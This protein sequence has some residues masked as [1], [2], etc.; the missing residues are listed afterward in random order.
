MNSP[1]S[2]SPLMSLAASACAVRGLRIAVVGDRDAVP[3]PL[4]PRLITYLD[5]TA[6]GRAHAGLEAFIADEVLPLYANT[7]SVTTS[8]GIQSEQYMAEAR[9]VIRESVNASDKDDAVLFCG[10]GASAASSLLAHLLLGPPDGGGGSTGSHACL[11]PACHRTFSSTSELLLHARTHPDGD[12][13]AHKSAAAA[14]ASVSASTPSNASA[15]SLPAASASPAPPTV[16]IGPYVHH[17]SL[18]PWRERGAHIVHVP[19]AP[20]ALGG[21]VNL[22]ALEAALRTARPGEGT[23]VIGIFTVASNITGSFCQVDAVTAL[24]HAHGALAV[25]DAAAAASHVR[26]DV[27][28]KAPGGD[29]RALAK[30]ALFFS[31]HKLAGGPSTPGVLVVKRALLRGGAPNLPGGGTV[32]FVRPDGTPLYH[33][34]DAEREEGGTPDVIAAVRAG[35]CFQLL[36]A[37]GH[38]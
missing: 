6:S 25:W 23:A 32:M 4:G 1:V 5:H 38:G 13:A 36:R 21:G 18:L 37:V 34:N 3:G 12:Q 19:E 22:V 31:C 10:R 20:G 9:A 30:D 24:C 7:H 8:T 11:F 27:N 17:S 29:A 33:A 14:A 15:A 2:A 28:P 16:L 26:L 35:L